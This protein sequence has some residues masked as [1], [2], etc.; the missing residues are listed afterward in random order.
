M[1]EIDYI[2]HTDGG[3]SQKYNVG[4]FAFVICD[5]NDKEIKRRAWKIE[6]ETNNRAELKA[7]IAAL[8]NLPN[9]AK[10]VIVI[11]DSQYALNTCSGIWKRKSNKDLFVIHDD[12]VKKRGLNVSYEW[13]KGHNGDYF[14]ELCDKL[15][16]EV[17]GFDLNEEYKKY[18]NKWK[19]ME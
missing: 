7:I 2:I 13:V 12:I 16:N 19:S 11:S 14:N 4:A 10:N 5:K 1:E 15:C 9:D 6:N 17:V 8:Y 18:M 3:Y